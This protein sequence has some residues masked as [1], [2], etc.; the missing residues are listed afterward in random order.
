M[1]RIEITV[2]VHGIE[3]HVLVQAFEL[4]D[5]DGILAVHETLKADAE[6]GRLP[7]SL[8]H[9]PTGRVVV[10]AATKKRAVE[11]G[12]ALWERMPAKVRLLWRG[13]DPDRIVAGTPAEIVAGE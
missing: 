4:E 1:T 5:T 7:W 6:E 3:R 8:T 12:E 13:V 2:D 11:L 10:T 9:V